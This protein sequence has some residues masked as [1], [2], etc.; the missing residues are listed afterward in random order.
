[1]G[2]V[3]FAVR[4]IDNLYRAW[5]AVRSNVNAS[6][7]ETFK[8]EVKSISQNPIPHLRRIQND[9]KR[10]QFAFE[11]Q[12]AVLKTKSTGAKRPIVV[13]PINNR[14]VQRGILNVLQS[15][16]DKITPLLGEIGNALRTRTSVGGIPKRG[17]AYGIKLIQE[18]LRSGATYY[19]RS[20]IRDFFTKVPKSEVTD[21]VQKQT[22]DGDFVSLL[23]Q[24][25]GTEL[26]NADEIKE[27]LYLFPLGDTGVPQGSSL[28]AFAGNV[29]LRDF[30]ALTNGRKITTIRYIDDFVILGA[31]EGAVKKAFS[32]AVTVLGN[33]GMQAYGPDENPEKSKCGSI[34]N[35][36]DFLGCTIRPNG[37]APSKKSKRK[38]LTNIQHD[39]STGA[40]AIEEFAL[41]AEPRRA[42]EA[43]AQI[44][45]RVDRK[46]RGWGDAFAFTDNRLPF[47]Q[48]DQ[49]IDRLIQEFNGR[50]RRAVNKAS[51][52]G[53]RRA[54]G[55]ALLKDT[56]RF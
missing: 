3:E 7:Q 41:S 11:K 32:S 6:G 14:I 37:V 36:F 29:V 20:D 45:S 52:D 35:G 40:F 31:S 42:G 15:E 18:A 4:R 24:A 54:Q 33:L 39:L 12:H 8:A 49:E 13:S 48:M 47:D 10:R 17:V 26:D 50:V 43:F 46:I 34:G 55:V 1:M 21:F 30:D 19:L 5:A 53:K 44:I 56:P 27:Y 16:N 23:E 25:L 9:L 22:G 28:S 51:G 38:L 2:K